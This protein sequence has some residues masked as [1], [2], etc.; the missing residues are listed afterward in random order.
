ML[1]FAVTIIN[2]LLRQNIF[3]LF[4]PREQLKIMDY[5]PTEKHM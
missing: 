5:A 4:V 1:L 3:F 2:V